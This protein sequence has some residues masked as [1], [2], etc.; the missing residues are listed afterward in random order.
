MVKVLICVIFNWFLI[1][2]TNHITYQ[3]PIGKVENQ[4][5]SVIRVKNGNNYGELHSALS[6]D[7]LSE[8]FRYTD[9]YCTPIVID[10]KII[11]YDRLK[12]VI[13]QFKANFDLI[14]VET[15]NKKKLEMT[16]IYIWEICIVNSNKSNL[17]SIYGS[18]FCNGVLCPEYKAYFN[19]KGIF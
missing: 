11:F 16:S 19:K 5:D 15:V 13:Q 14:E 3:K 4:L 1:S 8:E 10:Q 2:C 9:K 18:G 12:N 17:Y 6:Y 7:T